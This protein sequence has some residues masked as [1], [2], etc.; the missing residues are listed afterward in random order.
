MATEVAVL[1][2][3]VRAHVDQQRAGNRPK[4]AFSKASGSK[5]HHAVG[6]PLPQ[7]QSVNEDPSD[8]AGDLPQKALVAVF[9]QTSSRPK[10]CSRSSSRRSINS[11]HGLVVGSPSSIATPLTFHT[12]RSSAVSYFTANLEVWDNR[13]EWL[14]GFSQ[15]DPLQD[16]QSRST[17]LKNTDRWQ[18]TVQSLKRLGLETIEDPKKLKQAYFQFICDAMKRSEKIR[19]A[20][21]A[22]VLA[23]GPV[24][25][26]GG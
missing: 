2:E 19:E 18:Q 11:A 8:L 7:S 14:L 25:G 10:V 13:S 4:P 15:D 3:D 17:T 6:R 22:R 20:I 16:G 26:S 23:K 1:H 12:A 9:G 24:L 5:R 21:T